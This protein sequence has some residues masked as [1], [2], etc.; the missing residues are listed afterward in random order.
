[1]LLPSVVPKD[2]PCF[3]VGT[4][5]GRAAEAQGFEDIRIAGGD[6]AALATLVRSKL[7][8]A[9]G[10]LLYPCGVHRT[11][12]LVE[13]LSDDGFEVLAA[14]CYEMRI[15]P[16]PDD[17]Q[18][19]LSGG[20]FDAVLLYSPRSAVAFA[21]AVAHIAIPDGLRLLALSDAV[22][23]ALPARLRQQSSSAETPNESALL[24]VLDT[25]SRQD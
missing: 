5:T 24:D 20:A 21:E 10:P 23:S 2:I 9:E 8:E 17:V 12:D 4:T 19:G 1:M 6:A 25:I 18:T 14:P 22:R 16:L 15:Q 3:V 13:R 7:D 11:G